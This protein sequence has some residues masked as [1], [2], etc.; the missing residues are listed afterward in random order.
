MDS[1]P[2]CSVEISSFGEIKYFFNQNIVILP[3]NSDKTF[4]FKIQIQVEEL[5]KSIVLFFNERITVKDAIPLITRALFQGVN[6]E[7]FSLILSNGNIIPK[8]RQIS[9]YLN[10]NIHSNDKEVCILE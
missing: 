5:S 7:Q 8:N 6:E 3:H 1:G 10:S 2:F 4:Y 9:Y